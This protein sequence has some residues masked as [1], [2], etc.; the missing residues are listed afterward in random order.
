LAELVNGG[1]SFANK[2]VNLANDISLA[3]YNGSNRNFN[4]GKG[5][6]PIGR[7]NS[8]NNSNRPFAGIFNGNGKTVSGLFINDNASDYMGFF[9]NVSGEIRNLGIVDVNIYGRQIV[10]GV[11]GFVTVDGVAENCYSTGVIRA[12][13][14]NLGGVVGYLNGYVLKSYSTAELDGTQS[15][16]GVVGFVNVNASVTECY[17]NGEING[18]ND[19][20]GIA[21]L[22]RGTVSDC[23]AA[24]KVYGANNVG[25]VI[26][27]SNGTSGSGSVSTS[28]STSIVT[29]SNNVG[30]VL[31][32]AGASSG[33]ITNCYSTSTV[34]G[35][36]YVGG[37]A[38]RTECS[39]TNCYS[40]GAVTG[41]DYVGSV[42]GYM[43]RG[44]VSLCA[45][46]SS[47]LNG[48]N[49]VFR[50]GTWWNSG[51]GSTR[52]GNVAFSGMLLNGEAT[53]WASNN[54]GAGNAHG[55]DITIAEILSD[56]TMGNRFRTLA[57]WTIEPG[58]LPGLF[59]ESVDLPSH[60]SE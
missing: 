55:A 40:I 15:V 33:P 11:A 44:E 26:G 57:G 50:I 39:I 6:V 1:K 18:T 8:N 10:G 48:P 16:G 60:L 35:A 45:G 28:Y 7:Y 54:K 34:N 13:G 31:G 37:V 43:Y 56:P 52:T 30:G 49:N 22:H 27:R 46:L 17:Y 36:E 5:W 21:G 4:S 25:G 42:T 24:G 47:T 9:G 23:Y 38:G 14:D 53:E 20:G 3:A 41:D 12:A 2:T 19:V 59:G 29:G 58:K 32:F 51:I